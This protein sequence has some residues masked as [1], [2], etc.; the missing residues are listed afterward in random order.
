MKIKWP[1]GR[2]ADQC[3]L[4]RRTH[5][6]PCT[7]ATPIIDEPGKSSAIIAGEHSI[8]DL[9]RNTSDLREGLGARLTQLSEEV[10][11][12]RFVEHHTRDLRGPRQRH[13]QRDTATIRMADEVNLAL[14]RIYECDCPGRIIGKSKG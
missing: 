9:P 2:P 12:R 4:R 11:C 3:A 5:P 1:L 13:V 10:E 14:G 7:D 6:L 8:C